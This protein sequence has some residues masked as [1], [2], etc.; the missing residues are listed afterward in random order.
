MLK[1]QQIDEVLTKIEG[2][3]AFC[4]LDKNKNKLYLARDRAGEKPVYLYLSDNCFAFS[5][6]LNAIK[7]NKNNQLTINKSAVSEYLKTQYIP[8]PLTIY[9]ECYKLPPATYIEIN[10]NYYEFKKVN[11]FDEFK[12]QKGIFFKKWWTLKFNKNISK[13]K[14]Y[15]EVKNNTRELIKESVKK[16]LIS[17]VPLGAFLSS[18]VDSSLIVALMQQINGNTKTFTIGYENSFLNEANEAK[19]IAS[20]LSTKHTEL[21]FKSKDLINIVEEMP[22]VYSEPFADSSQIPTYMVSKLASENVKV[23]LSGDGGD[24]IFGGYNRYILAN[25]YWSYYKLLPNIIKKL[26]IKFSKKMPNNLLRLIL[27]KYT[28]NTTKFLEKL[29]N[30][31]NETDYFFSM[32]NEWQDINQIINFEY[33]DII[34][35]RNEFENYDLD[36]FEKKMMI[37][38]FNNYLPDDILCK[39]DRASMFNSLE[40]RAPYLDKDLIE[41]CFNISNKFLFKNKSSKFILKD[42]LS[43]YIPK[44]LIIKK[45]KGFAI[46]ISEWLENDLFEWSNDYLSKEMCMKHNLFNYDTILN[47]NKSNKFQNHNKIWS[48]IQFNKWYYENF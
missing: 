23:A 3:F 16:Q 22:K 19:L 33:S 34:N 28:N 32:I 7:N 2:M 25:K 8:C 38:D 26:S 46:P 37:F 9:N 47:L 5:S 20:H 27:K 43:D 11:S 4:F 40:T 36:T 31:N 12:I 10:L 6:D 18:G 13:I 39:V 17:D 29:D 44:E 30:I 24:E 45:K 15:K 42:I 48:I 41:Y 35:K 21:I 1:N 14:N